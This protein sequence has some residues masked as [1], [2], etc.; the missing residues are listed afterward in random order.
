MAADTYQ[1]RKEFHVNYSGEGGSVGND[2]LDVVR[3]DFQRRLAQRTRH[4]VLRRRV[5]PGLAGQ[6]LARLR[7][8]GAGGAPARSIEIAKETTLM[9]VRWPRVRPRQG[10]R[11]YTSKR[12]DTR[13]L[14][15]SHLVGP[16]SQP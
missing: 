11:L 3:A 2:Q 16:R 12:G 10:R 4:V 7:V 8:V 9:D 15:S 14:N 5:G 1:S 13:F 6:L